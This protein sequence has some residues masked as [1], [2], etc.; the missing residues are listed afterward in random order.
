MD[1][2]I[3]ARKDKEGTALFKQE[4]FQ[5]ALDVFSA[6]LEIDPENAV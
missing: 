2:E 1:K 4:K 6:A 5:E 3:V